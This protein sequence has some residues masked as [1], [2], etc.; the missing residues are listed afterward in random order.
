MSSSE[1][2][3]KPSKNP[4][5]IAA[6]SP[7]DTAKEGSSNTPDGTF[8]TWSGCVCDEC[9]KLQTNMHAERLLMLPTAGST[10]TPPSAEPATSPRKQN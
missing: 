3:S 10:T 8:A 5:E 9:W 6:P 1:T 4:S 7:A 2:S